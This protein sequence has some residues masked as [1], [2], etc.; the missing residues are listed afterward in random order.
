MDSRFPHMVSSKSGESVN[1]DLSRDVMFCP[2]ASVAEHGSGTGGMQVLISTTGLRVLCFG[3]TICGA[4]ASEPVEP[5]IAGRSLADWRELMNRIELRD[6]DSRQY[7]P[8]LIALMDDAA[9]PWFTRRQA[10]L[11]LGR[12]GPLARHAVPHV[13]RHLADVDLDDPEISPRRWALSALALFGPE[14]KDAAPALVHLLNDEQSSFVTRLGC[15][16]A[17]S[18]IGSANSQ[19]IPALLGWLER[20]LMSA[21]DIE[22]AQAAAQAVGMVGPDAAAAVPIL[23][24][25]AQS[26][27]EHLR[28][29]AVRALGRIGPSA[30]G[31]QPLLC[32]LMLDDD[33]PGV[34]DAAMTS[35]GQTG[36]AAWEFIEPLLAAEDVEIRERAVQVVSSWRSTA[37]I[38]RPALEPLLDDPE[39]RIQLAA[40]RSWRALMNK[41][42]R[43]WPVLIELLTDADRDIRRGASREL[44]TIVQ[45]DA[46]REEDLTRLE[47]DPRPAVKAEAKRLRRLLRQNV[48][49]GNPKR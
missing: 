36:P 23:M 47:S 25:R 26:R 5:P 24:R 43:V 29:E 18:Q 39:P 35:L 42:D 16:E 15:L 1:C 14:A 49:S 19:A 44:Q 6:P 21:E 9:V 12:L 28:R 40:A 10:A 27:Q 31:A 3:L 17:L 20:E 46:F 13:V 30:R 4:M 41:H 38:I 45:Q 48:T 11:T 37:K 34:R 32:D 2:L 8:G 33:S 22:L 7:V